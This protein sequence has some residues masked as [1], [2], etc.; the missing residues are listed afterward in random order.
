MKVVKFARYE[1]TLLLR[2]FV[3]K[4]LHITGILLLIVSI[5]SISSHL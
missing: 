3:L 2:D 4:H 5:A 1:R